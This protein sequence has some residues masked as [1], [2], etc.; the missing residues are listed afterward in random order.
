MP[1][2]NFFDPR[3][4]TDTGRWDYGAFMIPPVIPKMLTLPSPSITP[5]AF[6]DTMVVNGTAFPY[7][8]LP[9]DAIRFRILNAGNDRSLNLQLYSAAVGPA[10]VTFGGTAC[11][12]AQPIASTIVRGGVVTGVSVLSPGAGCPAGL[13]AT[14]TDV[15]GH[16]PTTAA[17]SRRRSFQAERS[18]VS[19]LPTGGAGYLAGTICKGIG[20]GTPAGTTPGTTW[21]DLCTEVSMV[22]ASV[23]PNYPTWPLDGRDGG[24]PDPTTQGPPWLQ[25]GNEAGFLAQLAVWPHAADH[26]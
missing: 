10:L 24:V 26:L 2:E 15:A 21:A 9:P 11:T 3:G 12:T 25:I 19:R 7:V 13:T 8:P 5:E 14:I 16:A 20:T 23:N 18:P 4:F 1:V 6:N 17:T 22:P